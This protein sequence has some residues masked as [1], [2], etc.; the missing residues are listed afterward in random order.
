[1]NEKAKFCGECGQAAPKPE[2]QIADQKVFD[3]VLTIEEV[4]SLLK[5]SR[6]TVDRLM[7]L[8]DDP[9]PFFP[10]TDN[11]KS[12]SRFVT[13]DVLAWCKRRQGKRL[14]IA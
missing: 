2:A 11:P 7:V 13:E 10:L 8:S 4:C 5:T 3:P 12:H 9:L 14:Q 1:M 6:C